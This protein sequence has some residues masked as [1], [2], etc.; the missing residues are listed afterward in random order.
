M[1]NPYLLAVDIGGTFT[2]LV[3]FNQQDN[4]ILVGKVLTSYPDP[5]VA[6]LTGVNN[7]LTEEAV[8]PTAIERVI[9]GTTLVTNTLIERQGVR[10]A[11]LTT[12]GFKDAL[13]IGNEGRYDIYDLGLIKPDPLVERR[14]RLEVP[15]RMDARGKVLQTLDETAIEHL[16]EQ[17]KAENIEAVAICFLHAYANPSHEQH[18]AELLR[19]H[20]PNIPLSLSHQVAP[21]MREYPRTST[22]VANAYVQPLTKRYLSGLDEGLQASGIEA[23]LN[24]MLSNGGTCTVDTATSFPIRLVESGPSGGGVGRS[25]LG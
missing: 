25:L 17:L 7:L 8:A 9:H 2:D 5:S 13:E 6:V 20:L 23:P 21:A 11:L 14:L 1:A 22:T 24:I 3:L 10:T 4:T 16:T 15:E 12:Q 19:H 18:A